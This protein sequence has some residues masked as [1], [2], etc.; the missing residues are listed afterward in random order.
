MRRRSNSL[1]KRK[2]FPQW[3]LLNEEKFELAI[4]NELLYSFNTV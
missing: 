1:L 3:L 4:K 2:H